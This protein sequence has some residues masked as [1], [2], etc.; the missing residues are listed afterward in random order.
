MAA[1]ALRVVLGVLKAAIPAIT[2][3]TL[4]PMAVFLVGMY[5]ASVPV[6][7]A[8]S[9]A[10][11]YGV[12]AVQHVRRARVSGVVLMAMFMVTV[13]AAAMIVS[14]HAFA[15][16]VVPVVETAGFGLLFVVTLLSREPLVVRLARDF[17]PQLV[18]DLRASP[19]LVRYVSGVWAAVY[20]GS[21]STTLL[22][23]CTQSIPVYLAAHEI[24]GWAWVGMGI[25]GTVAVL[26][27]RAPGLFA[28][29]FA[30]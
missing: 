8:A 22:L 5:V 12:G 28:A 7:V 3:G 30:G 21:A 17:V 23:L 13:R 1:R 19:A 6:A 11:A 9:I 16:F 20:L 25:A 15:Y 27:R 24:V 10:Y 26:R 4:I 14:G 29:I 2:V 18:D